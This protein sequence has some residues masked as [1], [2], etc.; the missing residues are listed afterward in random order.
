MNI[1]KWESCV[2]KWVSRLLAVD[3]KQQCFDDSEPSLQLF[4]RNKK[5]FLRKY[6]TIDEK[7]IHPFN[8]ESNRQ[9]AEWTAAD[10]NRLKRPKMQTSAG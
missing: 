4:Q 6:A 10:E 5:E 2:Q 3:Q 1:C 8:P 7:W 9:S